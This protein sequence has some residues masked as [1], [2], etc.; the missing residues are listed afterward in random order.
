MTPLA[1]GLVLTCHCPQEKRRRQAEMESKRRQL[2]DERRLLQHLKVVGGHGRL[3]GWP[4][5][6]A[7]REGGPS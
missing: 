3:T 6:R 1:W 5:G 2:E 4:T 7:L